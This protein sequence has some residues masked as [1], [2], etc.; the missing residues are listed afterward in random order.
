MMSKFAKPKP[1]QE[2]SKDDI[3][4]VIGSAEAKD[5]RVDDP[6]PRP[7]VRFTMVLSPEEADKADAARKKAG[8]MSRLA[9][10]R[11]AMAEKLARDEN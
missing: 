5:G 7:D 6:A 1:Q 3:D 11:Q 8:R 4:R 9:W 10:I 2:P